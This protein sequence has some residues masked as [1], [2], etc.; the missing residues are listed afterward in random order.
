MKKILTKSPSISSERNTQC[1]LDLQKGH[2]VY[3]YVNLV[4]WGEHH[5]AGR[6]ANM[7]G[8]IHFQF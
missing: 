3:I 4:L 6:P 8:D 2:L 5:S 1:Q 7:E